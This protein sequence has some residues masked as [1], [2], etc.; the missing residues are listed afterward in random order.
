M[1]P[2]VF[3]MIGECRGFAITEQFRALFEIEEGGVK[4]N[5]ELMVY[6]M[7]F[8][9]KHYFSHD[10]TIESSKKID[11]NEQIALV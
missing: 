9:I 3:G 7:A 5:Q 10:A 8:V 11:R 4:N 6:L 1:L 2:V